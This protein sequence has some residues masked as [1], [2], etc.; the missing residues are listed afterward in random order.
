M[1]KNRAEIWR[2]KKIARPN[3]MAIPMKF[4]SLQTQRH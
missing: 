2:R 4:S 1:I 3:E